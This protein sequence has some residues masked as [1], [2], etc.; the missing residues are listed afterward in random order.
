MDERFGADHGRIIEV[1]PDYAVGTLDDVTAERVAR[2]L[3]GCVACRDHLSFLREAVALLTPA[4]PR[5]ATRRALLAR[6]TGDASA[7]A[8][9]PPA[10]PAPMAVPVA[11][12]LKSV[13]P[14]RGAW[15]RR[16]G[17]VWLAAALLVAPLVGWGA[18]WLRR[19]NERD[20]IYGLMSDPAAAHML[21]NDYQ[22]TEA[23]AIFYV[24]PTEDHGYLVARDLPPLPTDQSYQVWLQ[25]DGQRQMIRAGTLPVGDDGEG[26]VL[27]RL[28]APFSAYYAAQIIPE[29]R[30]DDMSPFPSALP[31][32]GGEIE[33]VET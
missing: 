22:P 12:S 28:P 17:P 16:V 27:L 30:A 24:D 18:D 3:A 7:V 14:H 9:Q 31:V 6:A 32:L 15:L 2:H 5:T 10:V 19:Q 25:I 23:I 13:R 33:S 29:P 4:R 20:L 21:D 11:R 8:R 26:Q 1:L